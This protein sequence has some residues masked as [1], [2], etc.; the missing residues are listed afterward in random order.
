MLR[1]GLGVTVRVRTGVHREVLLVPSS[2]LVFVGNTPTL[3]VVGA[4]SIA[5]ARS[6]VVIARS[7]ELVEVTGSVA[8]GDRVVTV[9]AYGLPDSAHVVPQ[10]APAP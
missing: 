3:F 10:E 2:A 8:A 6:V 4:D 1:P 5:R 9:G 7:G